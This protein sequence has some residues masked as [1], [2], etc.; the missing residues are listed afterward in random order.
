MSPHFLNKEEMQALK[1]HDI[2]RKRGEKVEEALYRDHLK[3]T[4]RSKLVK[5]TVRLK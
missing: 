5:E 1:E 3:R 4:A 2:Y